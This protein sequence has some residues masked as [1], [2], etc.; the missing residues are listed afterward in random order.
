MFDSI[1]GRYDLLNGAL[2]LGVDKFWRRTLLKRAARQQ[3][4]CVLDVATG[5]G[6]LAIA[7][8]RS[9]AKRIVG[10][11]ISEKM[12]EAARKKP[13]SAGIEFIKADGEQ[14]PFESGEFDVAAI[15]FGIRNFENIGKGLEEMKRVLRSGGTLLA[16]ELSLPSNPIVR[17]VYKLYFYGLLPLA[18]RLVSRS[19]YA[20]RYLP[21][22]VGEFP[23][24]EKF[25]EEIKKV[26]FTEAMATPLTLGIA[27]IY[28]AKK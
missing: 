10:V 11:D 19:A 26:G 28:E 3:P 4:K 20:Y 2:S 12:L 7:L 23:P 15:A 21:L 22:S 5:T 17:G 18:G 8:K 6:S 25:V 14:L 16:L 27:T 1:S 13:K 9:G 24:R